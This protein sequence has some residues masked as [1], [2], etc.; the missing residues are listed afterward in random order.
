MKPSKKPKAKRIL[1]DCRHTFRATAEDAAMI[2]SKANKMFGGNQ[3]RLIIYAVSLLDEDRLVK[4][5]DEIHKF[6]D[7]YNHCAQELKKSGININ[8]VA[9]QLNI[10]MLEFQNKPTSNF[11]KNYVS[12]TL[13]PIMDTHENLLET[14]TLFFQKMMTKMM[15]TK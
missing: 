6:A 14:I 13:Q 12:Q 5:Y 2:K 11:I 9:K 7:S 8:Q 3:S 15:R 1:R 10:A 4:K